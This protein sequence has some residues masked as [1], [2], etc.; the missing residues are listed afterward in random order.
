MKN[1]KPTSIHSPETDYTEPDDDLEYSFGTDFG[2]D[3]GVTANGGLARFYKPDVKPRLTDK[4]VAR[5]YFMAQLGG[6]SCECCCVAC[7][8]KRNRL[9]KSV[10][11]NNG[12]SDRVALDIRDIVRAAED[13]A[14]DRVIIAHNHP[15]GVLAPSPSDIIFTQNALK[16]LKGMGIKLIEHY[17]VTD[18]GVCCIVESGYLDA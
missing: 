12:Q 18:M 5:S 11:F 3:P 13:N 1:S 14:S 6:L 17:I 4:R 8:D 2:D 16:V 7:L 10:I 15:G 9:K